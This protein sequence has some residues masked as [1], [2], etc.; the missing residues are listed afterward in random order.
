MVISYSNIQTT[1]YIYKRILKKLE[2]LRTVAV[3]V[4]PSGI[5]G[6][7]N[8]E[9]RSAFYVWNLAILDLNCHCNPSKPIL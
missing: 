9:M 5:G 1:K 3:F 4:G 2:R 7:H 6:R 8:E